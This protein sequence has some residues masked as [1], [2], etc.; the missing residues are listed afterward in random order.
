LREKYRPV[1]RMGAVVCKQNLRAILHGAVDRDQNL[2]AILHGAVDRDQ[3][4]R[5]VLHEGIDCTF[6]LLL[7]MHE[8]FDCAFLSLLCM[9]GGFDCAFLPLL[10]MHGAVDRDQQLHAKMFEAIVCKKQAFASMRGVTAR[11]FPPQTVWK[12][13]HSRPHR[14][15]ATSVGTLPR[16]LSAPQG[17]GLSA[18]W[19]ALSSPRQG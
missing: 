6:L 11:D 2:R 8:A 16:T 3:N 4:L 9:H 1:E 12:P 7:C 19:K 17:H 14:L 5:A 13:P 18:I 10:C 15:I